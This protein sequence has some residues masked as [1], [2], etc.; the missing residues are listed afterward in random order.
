MSLALW[1]LGNA[2]ILT[3]QRALDMVMT[4]IPT[5][6]RDELMNDSQSAVHCIFSGAI[7]Q[8]RQRLTR[9]VARHNVVDPRQVFLELAI[10]MLQVAAKQTRLLMQLLP[11]WLE[12][13]TLPPPSEPNGTD[14][15][16]ANIFLLHS[17]YCDHYQLELRALW[18]SIAK[19][20]LPSVLRFLVNDTAVR[21]S[22]D[23]TKLSQRI[24]G[25]LCEPETSAQVLAYLTDIVLP[26]AVTPNLEARNHLASRRTNL[27]SLY[28]VNPRRMPLA[29]AQSAILL[30][31][32]A[33]LARLHT[34]D[35]NVIRFL[36]VLILHSDQQQAFIRTQSRDILI[37]CLNFLNKLDRLQTSVDATQ[38]AGPA[39]V[40]WDWRSFWEHEEDSS[41][42]ATRR[43]TINMEKL[44]ED[45][46]RLLSKR[47][48]DVRRLWG[49]VAHEWAV[50]CTNRHMACRSF[51]VFRLLMPEID[52]RMLSEILSRLSNTISSLDSAPDRIFAREILH[53]LITI[54]EVKR[55]SLYNLPQLWWS[56]VACGSTTNEEELIAGLLLGQTVLDRFADDEHAGASVDCVKPQGWE[57]SYSS[58]SS[59]LI[60]SVRSSR[61]IGP[62]WDFVQRLLRLSQ[63]DDVTDSSSSLHL[64]YA[65]TLQWGLEGMETGDFPPHFDAHCDQVAQLA[66]EL[67]E[68]GIARVSRSLGKNRFR[69]KEDFV[70]QAI[71]NMKEYF[72]VQDQL[73][74]YVLY[75]GSL[76]NPLQWVPE[77]T[78]VLLKSFTHQLQLLKADVDRL[79][80]DILAPL[81]ELLNGDMA[82]S[83]LDV[84]DAPLPQGGEVLSRQRSGS[85]GSTRGGLS[86]VSSRGMDTPVKMLF[87]R[88]SMTGWSIGEPAEEADATRRRF[89]EVAETCGGGA[90]AADS[91]ASSPFAFAP[92]ESMQDV[93]VETASQ[94]E[95]GDLSTLGEMVSTLYDLGRCDDLSIF[96]LRIRLTNV[97]CCSFFDENSPSSPAIRMSQNV[98]SAP[99]VAAV[100]ARSLRSQG[101]NGSIQSSKRMSLSMSTIP[102]LTPSPFCDD[103]TGSGRTDNGPSD[104][105]EDPLSALADEEPHPLWDSPSEKD[106]DTDVSSLHSLS[107]DNLA[108]KRR[109]SGVFNWAWKQSPQSLQ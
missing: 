22:K 26:S 62:C 76:R 81:T 65:F 32:D 11:C 17:K 38:L 51:Q 5:D 39:E 21:G 72:S 41:S 64:I 29:S 66:E 85:L 82:A 25:S 14:T 84:L 74:T 102:E 68:D 2:D 97:S 67:Q 43:T 10:R 6:L 79:G 90:H 108:Q 78:L 71:S 104:D 106:L 93:A 58:I 27:D 18:S 23:F 35:P 4:M 13:I 98:S 87:G 16:L 47:I 103:F 63:A 53:T 37:R 49:M 92:E 75:L 45:A 55:T 91:R 105:M 15:V 89:R 24:L 56:F 54:G 36:H 73:D 95:K 69:T 30:S 109:R 9:H 70:R 61:A 94:S 57:S 34:A 7:L 96:S 59:Y 33:L 48:P 20:N 107:Q 19:N 52:A 1:K 44:I 46:L 40:S 12:Q 50:S 8:A 3:R 86:A 101:S 42:P 80:V 83:A 28:P 60:K 77:R 88:A 99:R 100:L 31:G